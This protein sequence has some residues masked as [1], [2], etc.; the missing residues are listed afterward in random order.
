[1]E[2][3]HLSNNSGTRH[4]PL[5]YFLSLRVF[6]GSTIRFQLLLLLLY[7]CGFLTI[8]AA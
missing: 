2:W 8:H 6:F 7:L 4:F 5:G 3:D 1:M